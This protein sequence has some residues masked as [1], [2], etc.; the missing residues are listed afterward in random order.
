MT[1]AILARAISVIPVLLG[2]SVIAFFLIRAVPGDVVNV[3][4]GEDFGDPRVEAELRRLFGLDKP[5]PVQFAEWFT[6]LLRLDLGHSL[7]SGRPVTLEV[8]E[9]FPMTLELTLAALLISMS[10]AIPLGILSA[11]RR[12]SWIDMAARIVSLVG[13]SLPNFWLGILL[14][15]VFAVY[16]R[17]LPS[18]GYAPPTAGLGEHLRFLVLP[19][20][21]LGTALAAVSMR[22][23]RSSLLEILGQDFVRTARAKGLAERTVVSRHALRNS[24]IPV[25]T[26]LGIQAGSLL[27][28]TVIVE[29]IF[30]WPGLGSMVVRSIEQRDYPMVQGLTI[31]LAFFFVFMSLLVDILYLYLDP[32]LRRHG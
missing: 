7:R 25:V 23:T 31:F 16:L 5:V 30:S 24:L 15:M 6:A 26:V 10:L 1:A 8:W 13:L 3:I 22:M 18:G 11:T 27:G 12:N 32:R 28:G 14:I 4:M 9:R 17:V 20:V 21:T 19:A 29:Q 2:I